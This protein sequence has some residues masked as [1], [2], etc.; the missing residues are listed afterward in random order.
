VWLM[1]SSGLT[2]MRPLMYFSA[3]ASH[4]VP[5]INSGTKF[6]HKGA[7]PLVGESKL[8]PKKNVWGF[9][10]KIKQSENQKFSPLKFDTHHS[11]KPAIV[12]GNERTCHMY[13][14]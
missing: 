10:P 1:T 4:G 2:V 14:T 3:H 8:K 12:V 6:R 7:L 11:Q 9:A 5:Q 13:I